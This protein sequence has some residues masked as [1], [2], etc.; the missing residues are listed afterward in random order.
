M[1]FEVTNLA[2]RI[3]ARIETDLETLL[4]GRHALRI[5]ELLVS[6]GVLYFPRMAVSDEQLRAFTETL[7]KI[8]RFW[9][10][11]DTEW[12]HGRVWDNSSQRDRALASF[13]RF[14]NRQ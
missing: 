1:T 7:G 11:L 2:P 12:A 5:R 9:H 6:R 13:I 10:T 3:G 4:S 14:Y 8:E